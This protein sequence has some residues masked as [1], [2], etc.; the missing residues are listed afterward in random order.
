M[1]FIILALIFSYDSASGRLVQAGA[2]GRLSR[3]YSSV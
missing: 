1:I 2:G 3:G